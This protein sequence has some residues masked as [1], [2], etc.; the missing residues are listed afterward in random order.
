MRLLID[1]TNIKV[2]GGLQVA[3]SVVTE[4]V[5]LQPKDVHIEYA[6]SSRV[7]AQLAIHH[8]SK[9]HVI[10]TSVRDVLP[11]SAG[12]KRLVA[13]SSD[14]DVVFTVF[15][16]P[17]WGPSRARHVIGFA[18]AWLVGGCEIAYKKMNTLSALK[19]RFVDFFRASLVYTKDRYYITE[20]ETVRKLFIKKFSCEADRIT[21]VPNT[22][23]YIY[24]TK[25][26]HLEVLPSK[27]L[28][29]LKLVTIT[30]NYP[31]K[32]LKVIPNV[33]QI[34]SQ[35]GL[36]CIFIV[37]IPQD[38][39]Q[40]L[41]ADFRRFTYNVGP[42]DVLECVNL[43]RQVDALF[44]PTVLECFSVSYLEAMYHQLPI[45][46]S[47]LDFAREVCKNSALYFDPE[48]P[49]DM[50]D[51]VSML[52]SD[53]EVIGEIVKQGNKLLGSHPTNK[54]R[55]SQYLEYIQSVALI[56]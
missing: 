3:I 29:C 10:N 48:S 56:S 32:N 27:F 28:N 8:K 50:A 25:H 19:A 6:V 21:V 16:P 43:Y 41:S 26:K 1:A 2:G 55:V 39:Y 45:L 15:G 5:S 11:F 36:R 46:T 30:H 44:L 18:N 49:Q 12:R 40:S 4:L 31:H 14:M 35:R 9:V 53:P 54:D 22:L 7:A 13:L 38:E 20:T 23:P 42:V 47:D 24:G 17:F 34:L 51:K 52:L 37:T 33:G